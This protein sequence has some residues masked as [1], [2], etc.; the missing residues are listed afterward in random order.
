M[1]CQPNIIVFRPSRLFYEL[2][3]HYREGH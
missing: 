1:V 3:P 2:L